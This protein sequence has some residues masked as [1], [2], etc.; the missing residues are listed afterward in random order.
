[1]NF[2]MLMRRMKAAVLWWDEADAPTAA[3]SG[4]CSVIGY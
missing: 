3:Y 1:M 4:R 2:E